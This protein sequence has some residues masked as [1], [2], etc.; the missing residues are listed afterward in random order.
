MFIKKAWTL[1]STFFLNFSYLQQSKNVKDELHNFFYTYFKFK[2]WQNWIF[3]RKI[4]YGTAI[5]E[6]YNFILVLLLVVL[7]VLDKYI[8]SYKPL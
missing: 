1:N 4:T 5:M 2:C 3:K 8:T 6:T 7:L